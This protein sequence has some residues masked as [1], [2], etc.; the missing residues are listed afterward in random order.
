[1]KIERVPLTKL[2]FAEKNIRIHTELQ[3]KEFIRSIEMFGQIRPVVVDED[4]QILAGNGLAMALQ[5]MGR[6]E[7]DVLVVR[8]LSDNEKKKLM[9]ADNR[10]YDLGIND[11]TALDEILNDLGDDLDIPGYDLDV[12]LGMIGDTEEVTDRVME[13]GK[14]DNESIETLNRAAERKESRIQEAAAAEEAT[15]ELPGPRYAEMPETGM[16]RAETSEVGMERPDNVPYPETE[17]GESPAGELDETRRFV[18]CPRCGEK[19]WL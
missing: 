5:E 19:I 10:I 8:G 18:T 11:W 7:V 17:Q 9:I 15:N 2:K 13:Y 12:L 4:Y 14:L 3:I 6:E 16:V 1:M